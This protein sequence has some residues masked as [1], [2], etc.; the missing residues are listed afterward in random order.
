MPQCFMPGSK[1]LSGRILDK[2]A[3]K[4]IETMKMVVHGKYATGQCDR[5]KNVNKASII[6]TTINV[7]YSVHFWLIV[8]DVF[9]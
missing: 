9:D 7:E 4:V 8:L 6:A 5:W 3:T 1:Q 2:E